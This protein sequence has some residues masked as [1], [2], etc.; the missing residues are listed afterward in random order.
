MKNTYQVIIVGAG[1][2]GI[3]VAASLQECGIEDFVLIEKGQAGQAWLDYPTDT[4]LL[5]ESSESHDDNMIANVPTS[6]IFPHIPHPSHILYQKYLE[7]VADQKKMKII[8]N[9]LIE[10]VMYSPNI[11]RFI[12]T[13]RDGQV[14]E[15]EVLVW[16][17]GMFTTPNENLDAEGCYIHYAHMPYLESITSDE[18]TVVGSANGASGVIMQLAKPGRKV[19][20]VTS[21]E[22]VIPEPVD[23]LWKEHMVF[24]KDLEK[25]GLVEIVEN[26]R[27]KRIY[28]Q[29]NEF[30]LESEDGKTLTAPK[31]PIVCTG[32][33][34]NIGPIKELVEEVHQ[35]HD[36]ILNIDK[37]HQSQK[38]PKLYL[39]GAVGKFPSEEISISIF[40]NYGPVIAKHI[41]AQLKKA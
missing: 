35:D 29:N 20:L 11:D 30:I 19:R 32:F 28:E 33:E 10:N 34:S 38:Q 14:F 36:H 8:D 5:S 17:A 31:K 26:F 13:A 21:R 18:I 9:T 39:A 23:C 12:L 24:I 40:R 41:A 7:Y 37:F 1:P 3:S 22:Y 6:K 25:Q 27:V 16:S 2:G 15:S 4:H